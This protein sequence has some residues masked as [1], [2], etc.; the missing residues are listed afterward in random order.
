MLAPRK[1]LLN[2][3]G[4]WPHGTLLITA[5]KML[6]RKQEPFELSGDQFMEPTASI[7]L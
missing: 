7:S 3:R 5:A 6:L 1:F 2:V 4:A